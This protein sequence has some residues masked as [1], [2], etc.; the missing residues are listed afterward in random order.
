MSARLNKSRQRPATDDLVGK[1][2][3]GL[4]DR[5]SIYRDRWLGH[6]QAK[7]HNCGHEWVA[8]DPFWSELFCNRCAI[9]R[10][11]LW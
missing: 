2:E 6:P 3:G 8:G 10:G 4:Q 5:V 1:A 9:K 7:C 11:L